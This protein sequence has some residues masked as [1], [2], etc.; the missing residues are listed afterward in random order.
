MPDVDATPT[1]QDERWRRADPSEADFQLADSPFYWLARVAGRYQLEMEDVLKAVGMDVPR[2]RV[3]VILQESQPASISQICERAVVKM[4]TMT[5]IV[6]RLAAA[7]LVVARPY[8]ADARVTE[9]LLTEAGNSA[10]QLVR[11]QAGHIYRKAFA[12]M[13][14]RECEQ[15]TAILRQLFVNLRTTD[16]PATQDPSAS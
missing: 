7:G 11:T 9:V 8:H 16:E 6:Q 5:R 1:T 14:G 10:A 4:S 15:L 13:S 2:W 12:E 3:L